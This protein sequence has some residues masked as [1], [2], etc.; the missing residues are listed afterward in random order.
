MESTESSHRFTDEIRSYH[1]DFIV[2]NITHLI[3]P[4]S[5]LKLFRKPFFYKVKKRLCVLKVV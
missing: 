5:R 3:Y 2:L 4:F 1:T